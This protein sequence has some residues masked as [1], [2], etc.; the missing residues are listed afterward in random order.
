M[1]IEDMPQMQIREAKRDGGNE[2]ESNELSQGFNGKFV[3]SPADKDKHYIFA[4]SGTTTTHALVGMHRSDVAKRVYHYAGVFWGAQGGTLQIKDGKIKFY[5]ES[6]EFGKYDETI[7]RP[8]AQTWME[9]H[10]PDH[11]LVFE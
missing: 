5:G 6:Y 3:V 4:E 11:E 8:I 7:V 10:L 2:I 9:Q 1:G